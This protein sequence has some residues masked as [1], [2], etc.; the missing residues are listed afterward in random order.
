VNF[1]ALT[2]A[3]QESFEPVGACV[4]ECWG[5][6]NTKSCSNQVKSGQYKWQWYWLF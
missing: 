3:Q 4:V 1:G 2:T 6:F 5:G